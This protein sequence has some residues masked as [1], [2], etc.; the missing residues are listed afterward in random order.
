VVLVPGTFSCK[1]QQG[2]INP[3]LY[4]A[5]LIIYLHIFQC[6]GENVLEEH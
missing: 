1:L 4:D 6:F 3:L 2:V 5:L